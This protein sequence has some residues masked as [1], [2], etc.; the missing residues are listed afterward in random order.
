MKLFALLLTA[1]L[2]AASA[3]HA[4]A[5]DDFKSFLSGTQSAR[6]DFSQTVYD[7]K[8]KMT[9][10]AKGRLVFLRPG[11]FRWTYI[12]PAQLIVGDGSRVSFFDEDLNQVT[13]RK[14]EK[15][16]ASTPAALLAG[17]SEVEAAFILVAGGES[18]GMEWVNAEPKSK[19][20]GIEK[21]RLGFAKNQLAAMELFDAFGNRTRLDFSK[22]ER[23][24]KI[25]AKEFVFVPPK[26]A[27]VVS[28]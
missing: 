25:D 14:L 2:V 15:A 5:M 8:G 19:D 20:A 27:D 28:E 13:V 17:K 4:A 12:K 21:V 22:F 11:K 3:V 16:F 10:Q 26:G 23:N 24:P 6:A 7:P 1:G 18:D 9:Q